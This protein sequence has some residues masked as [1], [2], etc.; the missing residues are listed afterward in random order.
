MDV[1]T[2]PPMPLTRRRSEGLL[3]HVK[4]GILAILFC[5]ERK[6]ILQ[7]PL[8]STECGEL[9]LLPD[10]KDHPTCTR[11]TRGGYLKAETSDKS[12]TSVLQSRTSGVHHRCGN[13]R[14]W[15]AA[16]LTSFRR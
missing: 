7:L 2:H 10:K 1:H 9:P 15:N 4:K 6:R 16:R 3:S 13:A 11:Q 8:P 12:W 14:L 5:S